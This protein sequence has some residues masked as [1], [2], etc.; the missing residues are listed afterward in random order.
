[1]KRIAALI[2]ALIMASLAGC[3]PA[4]RITYPSPV[5][6]RPLPD[7]GDISVSFFASDNGY[8]YRASNGDKG[9]FFYIKGV[10][11]GLTEPQTDLEDPNVSYETFTEWFGMIAEMNANTVR[12][13]TVMNP[14]FY[15]AFDDYNDSHPDSPLYL[16]QGVW[17]PEDMM[18]TLADALEEDEILI[19]AF[20]RAVTETVDI[21]HGS[22]DYTTYG[23]YRPAI[24]DRDVSDRVVGYV[25]GLEY[26]AEFVIETNA[27][28]PY[29][30]DF[31]GR[32]LETRAGSTPFEAFLCNVGDAL[33]SYETE[34]YSRQIPVAFLNWQTLDTLTHTDEPFADEE[35]AVSLNT[36]NIVAKDGFKA[37]LFAAVDVYP[38]YPEFMNH[39]KE[40][41]EYR[42]E[43]WSGDAAYLAYLRDLRSQYSVPLLIAEYGLSTSRGIGHIA[44]SGMSQGGLTEDEQGR[45]CADMTRNI[46]M[47]GC[48][49]G[50]LFSWQD[51]WF[52]RTWNAEMYYP[53][54]PTERTRNLASAEQGYG[55][56]GYDCSA[57]VPDGSADEWIDSV[58]AGKSRVCVKYDADYM[59]LLVTLPPDFDFNNDVYYVPVSVTGE[60]SV[61]ATE[62]GLDFDTPVDYLLVINGRE[63]T[64]LLCDAYRDVFYFRQ[65]VLRGI[66]GEKERLPKQKNTG[67]Y[68]RVLML[69]ANEMYL[70]DEDVTIPP[71]TVETGLLRYGVADPESAEFDS[72]SDFCLTD[73]GR[74]EIRLAWYL[75]GV[76]NPRTAACYAPLIGGTVEFTTFDSIRIGAGAA[77][78]IE[79]YDAEFSPI[80]YVD[81]IPRLKRSYAYMQS[82]FTEFYVGE[83]KN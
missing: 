32:Y 1:M 44:A 59:H 69:V 73:D 75:L 63:N 64:R 25:L 13:F 33:V 51:E 43:E 81:P 4:D 23:S 41:R 17:F 38:Y 6:E 50:L 60:G 12:V 20:K 18:Y 27:S 11:M 31:D 78:A 29:M 47:S 56:L 74:V 36:E 37:G 40:Y 16:I 28:H 53:A 46:A 3:A 19:T 45:F 21:I 61:R 34:H 65:N 82:V 14:D 7:A 76:M 80:D 57:A 72:Q 39:Q 77:G 30:S 49:G 67:V 58:G 35:D 22:S 79:L 8:F 66:Y 5:A 62:F 24:Y 55:L 15:R 68:D 2:L 83:D 10:N 42:D 52:K 9:E 26:P 48:C 70:P 71:Q 54:D